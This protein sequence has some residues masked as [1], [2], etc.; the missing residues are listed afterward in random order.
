VRGVGAIAGVGVCGLPEENIEI[1]D[2]DYNPVGALPIGSPG[3]YT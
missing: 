3:K 1:Y 2:S